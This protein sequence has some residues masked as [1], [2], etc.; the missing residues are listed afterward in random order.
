LT[1]FILVLALGTCA[2]AAADWG[3]HVYK[4]HEQDKRLQVRRLLEETA[5]QRLRADIDRLSTGTDGSYS[6]VLYLQNYDTD[7]L[8]FVT[9]PAVRAFIQVDRDWVEVPAQSTEQETDGVLSLTGRQV[10]RYTFK[11]EVA[12]YT[13]LVPGYMH[14]RFSNAMIVSRDRNGVGGLYERND[15]YY[16]YLKPHNADDAFICR[17]NQWVSAPMWIPMPPH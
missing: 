7:A 6:L 15:D 3:T 1:R 2:V 5:L 11:P 8:M 16:V 12:R 17:K 9:A 4:R 10:F 13:E 14:V